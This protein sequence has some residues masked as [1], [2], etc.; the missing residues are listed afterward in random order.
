M[1]SR[2]NGVSRN[3]S[4][5]TVGVRCSPS[6]LISARTDGRHR[7]GAGRYV[8]DGIVCTWIDGSADHTTPSIALS[9]LT[10][11]TNQSILCRCGRDAVSPIIAVACG[12]RGAVLP[13]QHV[14]PGPLRSKPYH[15]RSRARP[16]GPVLLAV[17]HL[18]PGAGD[19]SLARRRAVDL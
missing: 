3:D 13:L 1:R 10:S 17:G 6:C 14:L 19:L 12:V 11:I 16:S 8:H 18:Q 5:S 2:F 9:V 15:S 4:A 7:Y